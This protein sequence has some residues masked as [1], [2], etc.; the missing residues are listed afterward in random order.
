MN[1]L[2]SVRSTRIVYTDWFIFMSPASVTVCE[3]AISLFGTKISGLDPFSYTFRLP[4]K[5]DNND[6]LD[7]TLFFSFIC[8]SL[9][10]FLSPDR[11]ESAPAKNQALFKEPGSSSEINMHIID[12]IHASSSTS[13]RWYEPDQVQRVKKLMLLSQPIYGHP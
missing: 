2:I 4:S 8:C 13:P 7:G 10:F 6:W 3:S 1:V 9:L 12:W 11:M 5:L